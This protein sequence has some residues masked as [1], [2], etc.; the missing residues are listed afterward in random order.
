[1]PDQLGYP[2]ELCTLPFERTRFRTAHWTVADAAAPSPR[3][4]LH[5]LLAPRAHIADLADLDP[6]AGEDFWD[7]LRRIREVWSLTHYG[8][9]FETGGHAHAQVVVGDG[10]GSIHVEIGGG[11]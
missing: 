11:P 4:R 2:C 9:V 1:M 10:S 7:A 8:L 5:L 3:T 6:R